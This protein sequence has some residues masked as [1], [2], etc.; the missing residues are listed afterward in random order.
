MNVSIA[1]VAAEAY[2]GT[3][4]ASELLAALMDSPRPQTERDE[5]ARNDGRPPLT[6]EGATAR[7]G[8]RRP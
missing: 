3:P 4:E 6:G 2:P 1:S 7:L 5:A 8:G